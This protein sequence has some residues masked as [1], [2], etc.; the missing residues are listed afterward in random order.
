M[1]KV[2]ESTHK[3]LCALPIAGLVLLTLAM[4]ALWAIALAYAIGVYIAWDSAMAFLTLFGLPNSFRSVTVSHS[5][6]SSS[7]QSLQSRRTNIFCPLR[8]FVYISF[9]QFPIC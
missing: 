5:S 1:K 4:A 3:F 6:C 9:N 8:N 2:S 7:L